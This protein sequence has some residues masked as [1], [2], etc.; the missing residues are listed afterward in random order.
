MTFRG[1]TIH[2]PAVIFP[3]GDVTLLGLVWPAPGNDPNSLF[4]EIP[5]REWVTGVIPMANPTFQDCTV[6]NVA[7]AGRPAD[8]ER[9]RERMLGADS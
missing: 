4:I 1:A 7:I 9:L 5:V 3:S 6:L 8:I 2:G